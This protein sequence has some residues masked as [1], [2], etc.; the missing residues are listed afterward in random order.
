M[1]LDAWNEHIV[2]E[3]KGMIPDNLTSVTA[4]HARNICSLLIMNF[5]DIRQRVSDELDA[6]IFDHH[7]SRVSPWRDSA[8]VANRLL[9]DKI[10]EREVAVEARS[11]VLVSSER[12]LY[13]NGLAALASGEGIWKLKKTMDLVRG[14]RCQGR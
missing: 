6:N 1:A 7:S 14:L 4:A 13:S 10:A 11:E 2:K 5:W 9:S 12:N 8:A 3:V